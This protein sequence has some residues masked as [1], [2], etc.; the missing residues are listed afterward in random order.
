MKQF[1]IQ[2]NRYIKLN[3]NEINYNFNETQESW[4]FVK[5]REEK[6]TDCNLSH[7]IPSSSSEN[8]TIFYNFLSFS[9]MK[10]PKFASISGTIKKILSKKKVSHHYLR[11]E[12]VYS[13]QKIINKKVNSTTA[14][15]Y[16]MTITRR[17]CKT[18]KKKFFFLSHCGHKIHQKN[19]LDDGYRHLRGTK[20]KNFILFYFIL[21]IKLICSSQAKPFRYFMT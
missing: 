20:K 4:I 6:Y 14:I 16:F 10:Q 7:T 9:F 2:Q 21:S 11:N 1:Q 12:C 8:C 17:A 18:T 15:R 19:E 5:A 13:A 3:F